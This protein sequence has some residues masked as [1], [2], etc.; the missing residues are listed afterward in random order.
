M[1]FNSIK[2]LIFFPI[3]VLVYFIF[4]QKYKYIWLLISSYYFYTCWNIK[5]TFILFIS[6]II[7][8]LTGI[9]I[10]KSHKIQLENKSIL[11]KKLIFIIGISLNLIILF[12]FKYT[13]FLVINLNK[14]LEIVKIKFVIPKADIIMPIG[15]S[16]YMFQS[17][18][19]IIDVYRENI[20]AE[21]NFGKYA[22]FVSFFPQIT[23]GPIGRAKELLH[24]IHKPNKFNYENMKN[25]LLLMIWGFFL[26]LVLADRI[27]IVVN[28]IY[29]NYMDYA[30]F[31]ILIATV[32]FAIQLYC[33]F[34][35]YSNIAIGAA[36]VMG[37][38]LI[39]N[40]E[41]PYFAKS[42]KEFWRRWH[43]SLSSWLKDYLY[44]PLGGSRCSKLKKYRNIMITFLISGLWHGSSW[45]YVIWG[46]LH[47][48]YQVL[49]DLTKPLKDKFNTVFKI[50]TECF[51]YRLFQTI[52]TFIAVDFAWLFFKAPSALN[53]LKIIK[54]MFSK[55]NP[56][57]LFDGT[58]YTYGLDQKDFRLMIY[59][60]VIL[61]VVDLLKSK[62][63]IREKIS[64]QNIVFRWSLYFVGI[65][66]VLIFG[67]YGPGYDASQFI[68][69]QY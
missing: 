27:A 69:F 45:N 54:Q 28:Q 39:N 68:Y 6:T 1:V 29:D 20:K 67:I 15:I 38:K 24:Q 11:Y 21:K 42:V 9:L 40:F 41:Q 65:F 32:L 61:F 18:G 43:I 10:D 13:N 50:K 35:G 3:I 17:L 12:Y 14:I 57:I 53:A 55:F 66:A 5:Y 7:T 33:D 2:F 31:E 64:K 36:Q 49:D 46:F 56:W 37:F 47:G 62:M 8:Y 30:G 59:C 52:C 26:K 19:Y 48:A 23:S 4:P 25:G 16:F 60:I 63:K 34:D 44:I 22:L 51:S 58:L